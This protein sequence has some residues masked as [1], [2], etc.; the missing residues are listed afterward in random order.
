MSEIKDEKI[1]YKKGDD[2]FDEAKEVAS[3]ILSNE[4]IKKSIQSY[5]SNFKKLA[6]LIISSFN[7]FEERKQIEA[8]IMYK[9]NSEFNIFL[10]GEQ[11]K[12]IQKE[13]KKIQ[14]IKKEIKLE[15]KENKKKSFPKINIKDDISL[16]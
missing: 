13:L 6:N 10:E 5:I 16:C 12:I 4:E 15:S 1:F 14:K 11:V 3:K 2:Y 9:I 8:S 7:S